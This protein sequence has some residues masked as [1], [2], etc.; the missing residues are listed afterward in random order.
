[1]NRNALLH[2]LLFT[3]LLLPPVLAAEPL[4]IAD[5]DTVQSVL[6]AHAGK[7]VTLQTRSAGELTGTVKSVNAEVV[8]LGELS[9]KEFFDAVVALK[10]VD[11]VVIR[12]RDR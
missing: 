11:A 1:M 8:H 12:V 10:A 5:G 2:P 9:G 3:L 7:R 4:S 6:K